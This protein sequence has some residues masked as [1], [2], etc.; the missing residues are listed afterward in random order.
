MYAIR[1]Y[2]ELQ[3]AAGT[4]KE[5][6]LL[7][8]PSITLKGIETIKDADAYAIQKGETTYYYDVKS[9]LKVAEAKEK[10]QMGQKMTQFTYYD[11]YVDVK[12]VITSYSIHYT[13]LYE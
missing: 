6:K 11:N 12:G 4:F 10:E 13:K 3:D 8:N 2:Y 7:D 1:S 5:L 9:G